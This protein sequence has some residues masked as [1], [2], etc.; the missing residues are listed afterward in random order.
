[1]KS[2]L[3][4]T[5]QN[6]EIIICDDASKDNSAS[7]LEYWSKKD[8]RIHILHN[9]KNLY[10]AAARNRCIEASQGDY[11]MIQDIDDY[12]KPDRIERLLQVLQREKIDF[13]SSAMLI[14]DRSPDR[15]TGIMDKKCEYPNRYHF[16]W[17]LPFS[18]PATMFR[19]E[20]IMAVSGY[21]AAGETK[22]VE[23]LDMF[24]RLYAMGYRGKNIHDPL[25][26]Y[27]LDD[28]NIRRRSFE[29]R[30]NEIK[31][32]KKGYREMK[33]MPWAL[34]F[35]YKPIPAHFVQKIRYW[36]RG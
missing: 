12:S 2:L 33:M 4:Q 10:A 13:V 6:F 29:G 15:I 17:G 32:R 1:M 8:S 21:R 5:Y 35:V 20:C 22:R 9:E 27:R 24:M 3:R 36:G 7:L 28:D 31:I 16:L 19:R 26:V 18:H 23:D 34:P 14:F 30:K 11:L 25:Y